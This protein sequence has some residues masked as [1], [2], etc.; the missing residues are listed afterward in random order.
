MSDI[1]CREV[2]PRYTPIASMQCGICRRNDKI[3]A[4]E[5]RIRELEASNAALTRDAEALKNVKAELNRMLDVERNHLETFRAKGYG[6]LVLTCK[7]RVQ[8]LEHLLAL[9]SKVQ[10]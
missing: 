6:D 9:A 5:S 10:P 3:T 4:L 2:C 8:S 1:C 7:S